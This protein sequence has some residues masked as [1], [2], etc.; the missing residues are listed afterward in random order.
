MKVVVAHNAYQLKGGEDAVMEAELALLRS[1]G[2]D[3]ALFSRHNDAIGS[4]S[5]PS[6]ALQTI[7]STAAAQEFETLLRTFKPDVV[8]VHN[9]FP[10]IS[11][12]I[13]WVADRM[14]VPVVQT[15]HNFRLLCPQAMFLRNGKVC[16]DCLGKLPW[17]GVLRGCYRESRIQTTV[18]AGMVTIHQALG[19]WHHKVTRYIALNEFCRSKFIEGGLRPERIVVKPNF[20]VDVVAPEITRNGFLFVGRLSHEKGLDVLIAA[21]KLLV[22][23]NVR[24]A[25]TGP[26]ATMLAGQD[27]KTLN[28]IGALSKHEVLTEMSRAMALVV[29]S[30]CF[31]TFGLVAV[32][33]FSNSTPVIASRIGDFPNLVTHGETGLLFEP[34]NAADLAEKMRWAQSH[35]QAMADMG[36]N[37]RA[38]YE[39]KYTAASNYTQLIAIYAD[40]IAT[41]KAAR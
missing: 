23:T 39:A 5:A 13:Y 19:T 11:P 32:E 15:L 1:Q 36:R 22:D 20:V 38:E 9:T 31:E 26:Q 27:V 41:K 30:I 2:H 18:L 17:R 3:V 35:P 21:S 28:A 7:W 40:A 37:A 34:G 29:P 4:M 6:L 24:V 14:G 33:A 8:H 16:E 10:L 12:A 25:G